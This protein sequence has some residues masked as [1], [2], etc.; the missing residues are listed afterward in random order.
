MKVQNLTQTFSD[1]YLKH[2]INIEKDD[3]KVN[4]VIIIH[5]DQLEDGSKDGILDVLFSKKDWY[6]HWF[7]WLKYLQTNYMMDIWMRSY[8]EKAEKSYFEVIK[9]CLND[10]NDIIFLDFTDLD[11]QSKYSDGFLLIPSDITEKQYKS[12]EGIS[13]Y[14]KQY[15]NIVVQGGKKVEEAEDFFNGLSEFPIE[16]DITGEEFPI[17]LKEVLEKYKK[18]NGIQK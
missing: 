10:Y 11:E 16:K 3:S 14:I 2:Q 18:K 5:S 8:V 4:K 9:T 13:D 1:I 15:K 17:F 7:Y 6:N 12:L